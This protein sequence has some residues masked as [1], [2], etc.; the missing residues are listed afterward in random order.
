MPGRRIMP[1]SITTVQ[2]LQLTCAI[3][4]N[5]LQT[6]IGHEY[7]LTACVIANPELMLSL[8]HF[9]DAY[10]EDTRLGPN[11]TFDNQTVS[12]V[13]MSTLVERTGESNSRLN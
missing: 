8:G 10:G 1:C 2:Y 5:R 4:L 3:E 9:P 13:A 12:Q 6:G 11:S 7:R